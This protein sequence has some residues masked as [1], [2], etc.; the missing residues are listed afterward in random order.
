MSKTIENKKTKLFT[1]NYSLLT[2][3][4]Q[5]ILE[6][7]FCMIVVLLMIFGVMKVFHW[8]GKDIVERRIAHD[9]LLFSEV[10]PRDQ[11]DPYFYAPVKMNAI[12]EGNY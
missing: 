7:T 2:H 10:S 9:D 6:F 12:W 3:K 4:G 8:A 1:I 5:V 11:I